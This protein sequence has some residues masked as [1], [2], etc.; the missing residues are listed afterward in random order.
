VQAAAQG[1]YPE[2]I[3]LVAVYLPHGFAGQAVGIF[4]I[5]P[6]MRELSIAVKVHAAKV[7]PDPQVVIAVNIQVEDHIA[8]DAVIIGGRLRVAS[9]RRLLPAAG[10]RGSRAKE[11]V[12]ASSLR[13]PASLVRIQMLPCLSSANQFTS[14]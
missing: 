11:P 4:F 12:E 6:E 1:A 14:L 9:L 2:I 7:I 8:A 10:C 5:V 13:R 3:A